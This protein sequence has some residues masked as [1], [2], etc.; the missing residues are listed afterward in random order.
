MSQPT[1]LL[2]AAIALALPL[3]GQAQDARS[4]DSAYCAKLSDLYIHYV[5]T[6]EFSSLYG[7][8]KPNVEGRVAIAKCQAG[9]TATGI[10]I[11]ERKLANAK[12]ALPSRP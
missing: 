7:N 10:P 6:G 9:D 12:V 11:L 8:T 4:S 1:T 5:G 2:L 3:A